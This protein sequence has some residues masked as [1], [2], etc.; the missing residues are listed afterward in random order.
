M[1]DESMI[2]AQQTPPD[3]Q[4]SLPRS[5]LAMVGGVVAVCVGLSIAW[6]YWIPGLVGWWQTRNWQEVPC[7]VVY[8]HLKETTTSKGNR[9]V[10]TEALYTYEAGGQQ[11]KG[12]RVSLISEW[13]GAYESAIHARLRPYEISQEPFRCLVNPADPEDAILFRDLRWGLLTSMSIPLVLLTWFGAHVCWVSMKGL[14]RSRCLR[15]LRQ[16]HPGQPWKWQPEWTGAEITASPDGFW[17]WV[18]TCIWLGVVTAPLVVTVLYSGVLS[19]EP[20]ALVVI[21]PLAAVAWPLVMAR[22]R[23]RAR[24]VMGKVSLVPETWPAKPKGRFQGLLKFTKP[25]PPGTKLKLRARCQHEI[26]QQRSTAPWVKVLWDQSW[27][28]MPDADGKAHVNALLPAQPR[29]PYESSASTKPVYRWFLEVRTDDE[30]TAVSLP[31][32]VFRQGAQA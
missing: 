18:M 22:H 12:R 27:E 13:G 19:A 1:P 17:P 11:R 15:G 31:L 5:L 23:W 21:L 25:L 2:D 16:C 3:H 14:S 6:A 4:A 10:M 28:V 26:P 7:K 29:S 32:P 20:E 30:M 8:S 24:Q 9:R